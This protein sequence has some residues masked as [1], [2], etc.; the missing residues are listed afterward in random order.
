MNGLGPTFVLSKTTRPGTTQTWT[1]DVEQQLPGR[2]ILDMAYVG[3]H[4]DHL[5][6]FMHDPYQGLPVNQARGACLEVNLSAQTGNPACAGHALVAPPFAG[7]N[8]TVSQALRPFPQYSNAVVDSV[9]MSDPF[10]V[11]TYEAA[12]IQVQKRLSAGLTMLMN[13]TWE[14]TLTNA[15]SE[16]PL[17]SNWNGNGNSGA[18]NTYNLKV[19]KALSPAA[20]HSEL[21][22]PASLWQGQ[23]IHQSGS[24]CERT[25]RRMASCRD[26]DIPGR[27]SACSDLSRLELR[28]LCREPRRQLASQFRS[29]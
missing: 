21:H 4:G 25:C 9:T 7:F 22:L 5:Q 6:S 27:N 11:Y 10:G 24:G 1:L 26:S 19:E 13:Y 29:R 18:L 12:Q 2:F 15:D 3:D 17:Q 14:K 23:A 16:Y 20:T 28:N 8:G